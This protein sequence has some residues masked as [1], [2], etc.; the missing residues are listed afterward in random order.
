MAASLL[1]IFIGTVQ[2]SV[3][4]QLFSLFGLLGRSFSTQTTQKQA[5]TKHL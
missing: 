3:F 2:L 1:P 4:S 5:F